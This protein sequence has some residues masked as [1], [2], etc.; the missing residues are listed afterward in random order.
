[1]QM[2]SFGVAAIA[3]EV[4]SFSLSRLLFSSECHASRALSHKIFLILA[5]EAS[6]GFITNSEKA[7]GRGAR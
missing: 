2:D 7:A 6:G 5:G 3:F 1:M 4:I